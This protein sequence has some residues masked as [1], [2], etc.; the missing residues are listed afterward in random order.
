MS[1]PLIASDGQSRLGREGNDSDDYGASVQ[2][3]AAVA[4]IPVRPSPRAAGAIG[5]GDP[6][7]DPRSDSEMLTP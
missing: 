6:A 1:S 2:R 5:K 3:S 4:P 7:L